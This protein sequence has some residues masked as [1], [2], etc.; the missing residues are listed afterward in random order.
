MQMREGRW[1]LRRA[2]DVA[3]ALA[4]NGLNRPQGRRSRRR[5]WPVHR[6]SSP[7]VS[8]SANVRSALLV[9]TVEVS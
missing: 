2:S 9:Y 1:E 4:S 3:S 5:G 6:R 7:C 8:T